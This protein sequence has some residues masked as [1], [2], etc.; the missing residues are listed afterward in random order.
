MSD[1]NFNLLRLLA[2]VG[3]IFAHSF[4]VTHSTLS[5][6]TGF[7]GILIFFCISGYLI[8][9][10]WRR[11][12]APLSFLA[13][14]VLRLLP[15]LIVATLVLMFVIGPIM[16]TLPIQTYFRHLNIPFV[17]GAD[18]LPGVFDGQSVIGQTWT[19]CLEVLLYVVIFLLGIGRFMDKRIIL[20]TAI[21]FFIAAVL[22]ASLNLENM[23]V[24]VELIAMFLFGSTLSFY[25]EY[26]PSSANDDG[27]GGFIACIAIMAAA[28]HLELAI[29][30]GVPILTFWFAFQPQIRGFW[31]STDL[32]Y[33]L[34]IY[35][36]AIQQ[37][38]AFYLRATN[39]FLV[40]VLSMALSVP[41]AYLSWSLIEKRAL[42]LKEHIPNWMLARLP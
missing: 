41:I 37:S 34:Y 4:S 10:S 5:I 2:A 38:I 26:I 35:G 25:K 36:F 18:H 13:K 19:I 15:A 7:I 42:K 33:G 30:I 24:Y 40:F 16:T 23:G 27:L 14:R 31:T 20:V 1:N 28:G 6:P 3:V 12:P 21:V 22:A 32:S 8:T 17:I 11:D 9:E 39:P 29:V